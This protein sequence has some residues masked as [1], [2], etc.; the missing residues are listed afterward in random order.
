MNPPS[1][2]A[3]GILIGWSFLSAQPVVVKP[4]A[5]VFTFP[6][7]VSV[8][9]DYPQV[10]IL[11]KN[12]PD[13]GYIFINNWNGT[14]YIAILDNNGA[15]VFY[16]K[17]PANARDFKIQ[18]NGMLSYRLAD[19]YFR[20]YEMD[21]SYVVTR[22]IVAGTGYGTDEHELQILPNGNAVLIAL[23]YKT[24]DMSKLATGG[25]TAAT[26][27]GNTI[28]EVTPLGQ[29]VFQWRSWD[30]YDIVDAVHEN[31]KGSTVDY[32]H[33]NAITI[34]SDS[35][36]VVSSRHLSEMTKINRKTG[37]TMWHFGGVHNQFKFINDPDSGTSY[38]HDVRALGNGHYTMMDNGNYH[39][40]KSYSRAVEYALNTD[41]MT[42]T[43]VWQY[44]HSPDYYTWW[45]GNVQ[46][47]PS[48]NTLIDWADASLP[49]VTEVT[50]AGVKL[51]EL[52]FVN[53]A[54]CYR[55]FRFLWQGK[56]KAPS[57][58]LEAGADKLSL[59]F[60][61]FGDHPITKYMLY[62]DTVPQPMR[63]LDSTSATSADV[64]GLV[65]GKTY[66]FRVTSK[67]SSGNESSF[68][69]EE[70]MLVRFFKAGENLVLNGDFSNGTDQWTLQLSDGAAAQAFITAAGEYFLPIS[71][72]GSQTWSVQLIQAGVPLI[73]A[74]K[75][76]FEFD[77]YAG[78]NRT[79][80]VKLE[81]SS[82]PFANYSKTS[83]IA[84]TTT[85]KHFSFPFTMQDVTDAS[86]RVSLNCGIAA[87]P[88]FFDN[89]S[90]KEV[91]QNGVAGVARAVPQ[92]TALLQNYPN[93]F[94]PETTIGYEV[95]ERGVVT[96]KVYD[97]LGKCIATLDQGEQTPGRHQYRFSSAD[98]RLPSGVYYYT[99][100]AGSFHET[101]RMVI[102]K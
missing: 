80:D 7:G 2:W 64:S 16:R 5:S 41:S 78:S 40:P 33:M 23:D 34:D 67:D 99:L 98:R 10:K 12:K 54:N 83:T 17:M 84:L 28:Q 86:A 56:A 8:P 81:Q 79:I 22:E 47:L 46:R 50:P 68:S 14:P 82:T 70:H 37:A 38:Q 57:L 31:L 6:N 30:H 63:V 45:M 44:R 53:P 69:N 25:N 3:V 15:P 91:V 55:A 66:Y 65:N 1:L 60:N 36:V 4:S 24:V 102:L 72:G 71:V 76:L 75:Y 20:F 48:G 11:T 27:I 49:K 19:P 88:V 13:S 89:V 85:K 97:V 26:V 62:A 18:K 61:T 59:L 51:F 73:N 90:V 39:L 100:T 58:M 74:K 35:N 93:P 9:S 52:D 21:S 77:S 43:L 95:P 29:V 42:A 94:N 87:I 101:K 96:V 32:V 92:S